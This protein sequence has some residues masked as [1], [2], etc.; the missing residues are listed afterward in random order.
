MSSSTHYQLFSLVSELFVVFYSWAKCLFV[1]DRYY[2]TEGEERGGKVGRRERH[3]YS[4]NGSM[5]VGSDLPLAREIFEGLYGC[6]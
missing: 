1:P 2:G 6:V 5:G 3:Y 4:L